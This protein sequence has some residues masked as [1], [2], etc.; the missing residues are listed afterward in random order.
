M[1]KIRR[2]W[3]IN[4]AEQI[5]PS[6]K[7]KKKHNKKDEERYIITDALEELNEEKKSDS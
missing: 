7:R 6:K 2:T 4:P 3:N 5:V 1:I